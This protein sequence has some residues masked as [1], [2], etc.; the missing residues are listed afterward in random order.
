ML[1][2]D[3]SAG[4]DKIDGKTAAKIFE[5]AAENARRDL[6]KLEKATE[7]KQEN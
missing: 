2:P 5:K 6:E 3:P 1:E 4:N 7:K